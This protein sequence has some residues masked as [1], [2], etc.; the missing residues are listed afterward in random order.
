LSLAP[1]GKRP[2]DGGTVPIV[3]GGLDEHAPGVAVAGF[4]ERAP[5]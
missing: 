2:P 5:A 4:G 3:P 1:K